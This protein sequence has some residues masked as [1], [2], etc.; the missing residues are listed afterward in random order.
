MV[1]TASD[2]V[3]PPPSRAVAAQGPSRSRVVRRCAAVAVAV[4]ATLGARPAHAFTIFACEPEWA[5]LARELMPDARIHVATQA[6]QDPHHIEARPALIAQLRAADLAVCTGGSLEIGWLPLLQ[7]RAGNGK[8][9]T[10]APGMFFA[11]EQVE[12]IDKRDQSL[13]PFQGD[14]HAEGNPHVHTD[15]LRMLM[16]SRRLAERMQDLAREQAPAIEERHRAFEQRWK[17]QID[18]WEMKVQPLRGA[19]VAAQHG[20]FAYL[21]R[22]L[23]VEQVADLEPRPG[24]S[25]TPGHLQSLLQALRKQPPIAVVIASFHDPRAGRWVVGQ[26]EGDVPLIVLPAGPADPN[27]ADAL[28]RWYDAILAP[29]VD[30]AARSARN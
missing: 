18:R 17:A 11:T 22:W 15:P 24:L 12:L 4:V 13:S 7:E 20:T 25:P 16:V 14:V 6:R 1:H 5:A 29:L 26:L 8:I 10:G 21:W 28:V 30:A 2:P 27:G 23:G 19:R 9:Q 3:R